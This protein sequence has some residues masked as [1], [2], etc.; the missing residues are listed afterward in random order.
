MK[1][2]TLF[3]TLKSKT[4]LIIQSK[5]FRGGL[6]QVFALVSIDGDLPEIYIM[7]KLAG[8]SRHGLYQYF[9]PASSGAGIGHLIEDKNVNYMN[10]IVNSFIPGEIQVILA[11]TQVKDITLD[12]YEIMILVLENIS[13]EMITTILNSN[14]VIN[15]IL[16][17]R[18]IMLPTNFYNYNS[19]FVKFDTVF[20]EAI[21]G[22]MVLKPIN[23]EG[24]GRKFTIELSDKLTSY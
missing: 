10:S 17:D 9:D 3:E 6:E 13:L 16:N 7:G 23:M 24:K 19:Y 11:M 1:V 2:K 4:N 20:L 8:F 5:G 15:Q 21:D 12:S 18:T 22:S 14:A